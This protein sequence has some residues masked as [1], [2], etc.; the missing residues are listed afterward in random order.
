[1]RQVDVKLRAD[2]KQ[3]TTKNNEARSNISSSKWSN[4]CSCW[5]D[6]Q[7]SETEKPRPPQTTK[8]VVKQSR[9]EILLKWTMTRNPLQACS[10]REVCTRFRT[11]VHVFR[12]VLAS[13]WNLG[14]GWHTHVLASSPIWAYLYLAL[15]GLQ[16]CV[17]PW[18]VD[19]LA[20]FANFFE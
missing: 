19:N 11:K 4:K 6:G 1:M 3:P 2:E 13:L 18:N 17:W 16:T 10:H 7:E 14:R 8:E 9:Q 20:K 5:W 15:I 12:L